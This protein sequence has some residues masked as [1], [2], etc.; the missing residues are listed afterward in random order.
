MVVAL[1]VVA[2]V[3]ATLLLAL[4]PKPKPVPASTVP[5]TPE[6]AIAADGP[7]QKDEGKGGKVTG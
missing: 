6:P 1:I 5:T 2:L 4:C 3:V 7:E